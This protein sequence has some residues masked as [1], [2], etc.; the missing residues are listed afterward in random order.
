MYK[1]GYVK[2]ALSDEIDKVISKVVDKDT[3]FVLFFY[4][5]E[6]DETVLYEKLKN[7]GLPFIGCMDAGR[8]LNDSYYHDTKTIS[9]MSFSKGLFE[10][11]AFGLVDMSDPTNR[12]KITNDSQ[13]SL[14]NAAKEVGIDINYPDMKR[15]FCI[16]LVYGLSSATPY[17][18]GQ[19]NACM[20]LQTV[21]GSSGGKTDFLHTS[22]MSHLGMGKI[23]AFV[24]VRLADGFEFAMNR[25]TSFEPVSD[26]KLI[27]TALKNERHIVEFN[28]R[29]AQEQYCSLLSIEPDKLNPE[30]FSLFTLGMEP[31]DGE[32]LITSIQNKDKN[33]GF[34]TY[35]DVVIGTEFRLYKAVDQF[36]KRLSMLK[37]L[38]DRD[39]VGYISFDCI[40]CY[41]A[42]NAMHRVDDIAKLYA[43][44]LLH[45]PKIG[46]GTF[47][48]NICGVNIN[49]TE[50]YLAILKNNN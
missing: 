1:R 16:N 21:G 48:E 23:G 41:L 20:M 33:G 2:T 50:T 13:T 47:S 9:A 27:V 44:N 39:V 36:E 18:N 8:L 34:F 30:I 17:L 3:S 40:L 28:N 45:V 19:V 25:V 6:V 4:G 11:T 29:P 5:A 46:F 10:S 37:R 42:R 7:T 15:D 49:Q 14:I 31:G 32:L 24:L 22:V 35:N 38:K 26:V 43:D 12:D